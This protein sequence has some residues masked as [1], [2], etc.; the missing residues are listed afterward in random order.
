MTIAQLPVAVVGCGVAGLATALAAAP[1]PVLLIGRQTVGQDCASALAQ[2]GIAAAIGDGDSPAEHARDT[3][4]AGAGHNR[5]DAVRYLVDHAVVAV[6]WLQT[7]GVEFDSDGNG[8]SLGREGGH[9][10][11]RILHAGGDASGAAL[12]AALHRAALRAPHIQWQAPCEVDGLLLRG[13][14]VAGVRVRDRDGEEN[15]LE[16][17]EVALA[18]GGIGALF[19]ATT[20][21][22]GADGNGLALA[23]AAGAPVQDLEFMQFHPTALAVVGSGALPLITEALR[24]AGAMLY[25]DAGARIMAGRHP[26]ADLAPRDLVARRVWQVLQAGGR[27]WLDATAV[28]GDWQR[29]FP[30]VDAICRRHGIDPRTQRIPVTPAAHFHMGGIAVDFDGRTTIRGLHAV[31]EAACNGV[32]GANRLASNSLLEGLVFGR[33]LGRLLADVRLSACRSGSHRLVERG[34]SATDSA[35]AQLRALS[36]QALGPVRDG[37][38]MQQAL[39]QI[40]HDAALRSCW[41][42]KL[43]ARM[44]EAALQRRHS[45]GA[46]YR[47]DAEQQQS[48]QPM[49][50][51]SL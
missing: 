8:L 33:R 36:W 22:A 49:Q 40:H 12:V 37:A 14:Q 11:H 41:H 51:C 17:S 31:G 25:D 44:L 5:P 42:G 3:L 50:P 18:T 46:H 39:A 24:G 47:R 13:E 6:R 43:V 21:P 2:G 15:V 10:L 1:R 38:T 27:A 32:H 23:M 7:L 28:T 4:V 45:M 34:R 29:R 16:C 20:N 9:H 30:T 35:L 26:L 19:A 48:V